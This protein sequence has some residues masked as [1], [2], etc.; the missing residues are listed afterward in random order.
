MKQ[1]RLDRPNNFACAI[2][3]RKDSTNGII[4]KSIVM[5]FFVA[6]LFACKPDIKAVI[7]YSGLDTLP[8]LTARDVEFI[9]SDS[10]EVQAVLTSKLMCS[11]SGKEEYLEFPEGF[12]VVF[13]DSIGQVQSELTADYGI[14]SSKKKVME[15][16]RNVCIINFEK[17]EKLNTQK[18]IWDQKKKIIYSDVKVKITTN[19]DILYG[20]G[21]ESDE[22]FSHYEIFNPT[23]ELELNEDEK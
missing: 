1:Q 20:S 19:E 6:M 12:K 4:L 5:I 10:G 23:G 17:N 18:L 13:F 21:L 22:S 11:Y 15:A 7:V 16:H 8:E 14:N 2:L 3:K 9:R